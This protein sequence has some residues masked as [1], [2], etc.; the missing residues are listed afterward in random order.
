MSVEALLQDSG[1]CVPAEAARSGG[2]DAIAPSVVLTTAVQIPPVQ[3][4]SYQVSQ[5]GASG[6]LTSQSAAASQGISNGKK[7]E[8]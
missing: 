6:Q 4:V 5:G 3:P 2:G 7:F 8:R 1:D